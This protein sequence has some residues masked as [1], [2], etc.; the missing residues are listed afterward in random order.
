MF[1]V[2]LLLNDIAFAVWISS[3]NLIGESLKSLERIGENIL[4]GFVLQSTKFCNTDPTSPPPFL[5]LAYHYFLKGRTCYCCCGVGL[6][7][8]DYDLSIGVLERKLVFI[9][10][11]FL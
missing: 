7:N 10:I 9:F 2:G 4:D 3:V 8:L 1:Q 11:Y 6:I 5:D